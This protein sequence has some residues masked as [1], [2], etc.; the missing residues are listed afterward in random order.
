MNRR[1]RGPAARSVLLCASLLLLGSPAPP[2]VAAGG[3]L[4]LTLVHPERK[5]EVL[6]QPGAEVLHVVFFATWCPPCVEELNR[7]AD[8]DARWEE[9]GYRLVVVA[10][11]ARHTPERL[12][13]FAAQH[14]PPGELYLDAS[15]QAARALGAE[16]VPTHVLLDA[17]GR[18]IHRADALDDGVVEALEQHM[19]RHERGREQRK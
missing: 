16:S 5:S 1:R 18:L 14:R 4:S 9:R 8:L 6:L 13:R 3:D 2:V 10:V 15:G 17:T 19:R 12:A 11:R 7:L